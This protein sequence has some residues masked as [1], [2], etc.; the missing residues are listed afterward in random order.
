MLDEIPTHLDF[1]IVPALGK[2]LK[3]F[4]GAVLLVSHDRFPTKSVIEGDMS[5]LG[6]GEEE[7]ESN[8]DAEVEL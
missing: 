6:L 5:L 3:A 7:S 4:I 2:S 1:H 8:E